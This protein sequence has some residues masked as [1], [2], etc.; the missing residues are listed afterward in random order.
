MKQTGSRFYM[1]SNKQ[2]PFEGRRC[3][4]TKFIMGDTACQSAFKIIPPGLLYG[5][6]KSSQLNNWRMDMQISLLC[7]NF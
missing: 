6:K 2:R 4:R 7:N 5:V 3:W 1:P